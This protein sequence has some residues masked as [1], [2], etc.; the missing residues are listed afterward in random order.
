MD[1]RK[2]VVVSRVKDASKWEKDD[3]ACFVVPLASVIHLTWVFL[4][5][6]SVELGCEFELVLSR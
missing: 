3:P 6:C 1:M 4:T 2:F 5:A